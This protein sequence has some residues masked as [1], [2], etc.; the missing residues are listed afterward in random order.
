VLSQNESLTMGRKCAAVVLNINRDA[1]EE[2]EGRL[3]V[4]A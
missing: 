4:L 2:G 3:V 1:L